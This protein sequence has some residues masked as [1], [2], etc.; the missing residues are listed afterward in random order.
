MTTSS[1][2]FVPCWFEA[3]RA[4]HFAINTRFGDRVTCSEEMGDFGFEESVEVVGGEGDEDEGGDEEDGDVPADA[5]D[6]VG[7]A[8]F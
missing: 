6:R 1:T 3:D 5:F 7:G 8:R 4:L 2:D